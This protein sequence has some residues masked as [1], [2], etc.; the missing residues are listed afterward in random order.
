MWVS[1]CLGVVV[2]GLLVVAKLTLSTDLATYSLDE[3]SSLQLAVI[4]AGILAAYRLC[5]RL[6]AGGRWSTEFWARREAR[7]AEGQASV[8][9]PTRRVA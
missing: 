1:L 5:R 8:S 6:R 7:R 3:P 9:E 2:I 4:G